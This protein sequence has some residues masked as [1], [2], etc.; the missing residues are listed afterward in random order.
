MARSSSA[1]DGGR[2]RLE[3]V[4]AE[5]AE[6]GPH[7]PR[8]KRHPPMSFAKR[9]LMTGLPVVPREDAAK[10]FD[11]LH[12]LIT[13]KLLKGFPFA[14]DGVFIPHGKDGNTFGVA[15]IEFTDPRA[16][17]AAC[18]RSGDKGIPIT[19]TMSALV[20]PLAAVQEA[21]SEPSDADFKPPVVKEPT[22]LDHT[23]SHLTDHAARDQLFLRFRQRSREYKGRG[24]ADELHVLWAS[25]REPPQLAYDGADQKAYSAEALKR[26]GIPESE[27]PV[28]AWTDSNAKWSPRGTFL[29]TFHGPGV[30]L[31]AGPRFAEVRGLPHPGVELIRFSAD[32]RHAITFSP[33]HPEEPPLQRVWDIRTGACLETW[34]PLNAGELNPQPD[35]MWLPDSKHIVRVIKAGY[36]LLNG[37]ERSPGIVGYVVESGPAAPAS[38]AAAASGAGAGGDDAEE[39][40]SADRPARVRLLTNGVLRIAAVHSARVAPAGPSCVAVF[41]L[42]QGALQPAVT[43]VAV[44]AMA[45]L[46]EKKMVN[47]LCSHMHWHPAGKFLAVRSVLLTKQQATRQ[48]KE[49]SRLEA[50]TLG[51]VPPPEIRFLERTLNEQE[52][53]M[54]LRVKEGATTSVDIFRLDAPGLQDRIAAATDAT[55]LDP[56]MVPVDVLTVQDVVRAITFE[57]SGSRVALVHGDPTGASNASFFSMGEESFADSEGIAEVKSIVEGLGAAAKPVGFS[58]ELADAKVV[59]TDAGPL[60]TAS[61]KPAASA[62]G[63]AAVPIGGRPLGAPP[64][65]AGGRGGAGGRRAG[66]GGTRS[67]KATAAARAA[68]TA[69]RAR[70]VNHLFTMLARSANTV[71]WSPAGGLAV[72]AE[73]GE[74][75]SGSLEF[76]D[77]DIRRTVRRCEHPAASGACFSPSGRIF[78]TWKCQPLHDPTSK[79]TVENAMRVYSAHGERLTDPAHEGADAVLSVGWRP[80]PRILSAKETRDLRSSLPALIAGF[81]REDRLR[82]RKRRLRDL[83][84][85]L[86]GITMFER[87]VAHSRH[88]LA[89]LNDRR[90]ADGLRPLPVGP[91]ASPDELEVQDVAEEVVLHDD[92]EIIT[93]EQLL[94]SDHGS[95]DTTREA[96]EAALATLPTGIAPV[97]PVQRWLVALGFALEECATS[98]PTVLAEGTADAVTLPA[99]PPAARLLARKAADALRASAHKNPAIPRAAVYS[100]EVLPALSCGTGA[101]VISRLNRILAPPPQDD[102]ATP[103]AAAAAANPAAALDDADADALYAACLIDSIVAHIDATPKQY[104]MA[105][106]SDSGRLATVFKRAR[107]DRAALTTACAA[108]GAAHSQPGLA[109]QLRVLSDRLRVSDSG[110]AHSTRALAAATRNALAHIPT[111]FELAERLAEDSASTLNSLPFLSAHPDFSSLHHEAKHR[112]RAAAHR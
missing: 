101:A 93:P 109:A 97:A 38:G 55:S 111:V 14:E 71:I 51:V 73:V 68:A 82:E 31:W 52:A 61:I 19:K 107:I 10:K 65:A 67:K 4:R 41:S 60:A 49:Q 59:R 88:L 3:E 54:T 56:G 64:A 12:A 92:V 74:R 43:L 87:H 102:A 1:A 6:L 18:K 9:V 37:A 27:L 15:V 105:T 89:E 28:P 11:K 2:S 46:R 36:T 108:V 77:V 29:A 16:V 23:M 79:E 90:V 24:L 20:R 44:P 48:R 58:F 69:A 8:D 83:V 78:A 76:V 104:L 33:G 72:V 47:I 103:A 17:L 91:T 98:A 95:A 26:S 70:G 30:K 21:R 66:G 39:D 62:S 42:E 22:A 57:P 100:S 80:H 40:E 84:R 35:A 32:E 45:V 5:I 81:K 34:E 75:S 86:H 112:V 110:A 63:A 106:G 94:S 13:K 85:R 25:P 96:V 7:V 99:L 53:E 50:Q